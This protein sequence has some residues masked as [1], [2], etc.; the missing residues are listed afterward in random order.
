M[1][2]V[3]VITILTNKK[4]YLK[5][6]LSVMPHTKKW[7]IKKERKINIFSISFFALFNF[8]SIFF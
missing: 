8:F 3:L 5:N 4:I 2:K 1:I 7:E 6:A